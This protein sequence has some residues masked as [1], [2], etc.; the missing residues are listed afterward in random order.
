[1]CGLTH[2]FSGLLISNQSFQG[3]DP[4]LAVTMFRSLYYGDSFIQ[5]MIG[6]EL[7]I[8][9]LKKK[10]MLLYNAIRR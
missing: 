9:E 3:I 6:S 10:Y 2:G 4:L 5:F 1:M 8:E 7:D